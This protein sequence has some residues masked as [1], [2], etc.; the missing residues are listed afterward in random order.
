MYLGL[1]GAF[2]LTLVIGFLAGKEYDRLVRRANYN[3]RLRR[4]RA[5]E[6]RREKH[7]RRQAETDKKKFDYMYAVQWDAP[8]GK[9]VY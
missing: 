9:G 1:V 8:T 2:M 3:R 5:E 7:F 6:I 4:E